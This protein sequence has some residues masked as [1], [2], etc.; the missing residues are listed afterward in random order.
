MLLYLCS[1]GFIFNYKQSSVACDLM[2]VACYDAETM[3][4]L[5]QTFSVFM[6]C[7]SLCDNQLVS[8]MCPHV[9]VYSNCTISLI[10]V[11]FYYY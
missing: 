6:Q 10:L 7:V 1:C 9:T 5:F 3:A 2:P 11:L 8:I 4:C